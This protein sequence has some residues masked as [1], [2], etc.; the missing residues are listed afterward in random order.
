MLTDVASH[1]DL[2]QSC[3]ITIADVLRKASEA[4]TA[5]PL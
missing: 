4:A 5:N 2:A 3:H 1:W